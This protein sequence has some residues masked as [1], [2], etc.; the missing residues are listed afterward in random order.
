MKKKKQLNFMF[1]RKLRSINQCQGH[2]KTT[3]AVK[4]KELQ[5][6]FKNGPNLNSPLQT[7]TFGGTL[8]STLN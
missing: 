2:V 1:L 8:L 3:M 7:M 5:H 4:Y 6:F